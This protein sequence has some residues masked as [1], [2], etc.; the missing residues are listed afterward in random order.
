MADDCRHAGIADVGR[1]IRIFVNPNRGR[2]LRAS[3]Q[4]RAAG[5]G[6]H[7]SRRGEKGPHYFTPCIRYLRG[8]LR[9]RSDH[10]E[11]YC[12]FTD[13]GEDV[14]VRVEADLQ[15]G[16]LSADRLN[17]ATCATAPATYWATEIDRNQ[18]P[19]IR[20]TIR[21]IDSLVIMR[22]ADR[23]DHQLGDRVDEIESRKPPH[24][25]LEVRS[26]E[27]RAPHQEQEA[28]PDAHEREPELDRDRR[29][30][31]APRQAVPQIENNGASRTMKIALKDCV[32]PAEIDQLLVI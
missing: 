28:R 13:D 16:D 5:Q 8:Q 6:E 31:S 25:D 27:L 3:A 30:E 9:S 2:S 32:W 1:R 7:T 10:A 11:T 21:A 17:R 19:I 29:F 23:R 12:P 18:T 26:G 22:Q 24:S 4:I 20:P 14:K 15:V